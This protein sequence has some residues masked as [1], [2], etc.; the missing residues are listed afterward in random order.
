MDVH[1]TTG[2]ELMRVAGKL[3]DGEGPGRIGVVNPY[4]NTVVGTVP[5]ASREQVAE[6]LAHEAERPLPFLQTAS[7]R[8]Q[9]ALDAAVLESVPPAG[10]VRVDHDSPPS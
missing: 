9:I 1:G 3:V 10:R 4:D 2:H 8:T 6:A 5:R 7:T